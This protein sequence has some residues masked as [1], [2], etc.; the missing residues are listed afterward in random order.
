MLQYETTRVRPER[1]T[2]RLTPLSS[3]KETHSLAGG[4]AFPAVGDVGLVWVV[5]IPQQGAGGWCAA[6]P[7]GAGLAEL[8]STFLFG[9]VLR[10]G[11]LTPLWMSHP[12]R[13]VLT[14]YRE[15]EMRETRL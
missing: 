9:A 2:R 15:T 11:G 4:G 5:G 3:D 7:R 14:H 1:E 13:G 6:A 12:W 8:D 10:C